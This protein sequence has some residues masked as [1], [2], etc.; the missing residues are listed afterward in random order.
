MLVYV[1]VPEMGSGL[2]SSTSNAVYNPV[3]S[4]F[5]SS[6][7][8]SVNSA[9]SSASSLQVGNNNRC[10]EINPYNSVCLHDDDL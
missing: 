8:H 10:G 2:I 9:T 3:G 6:V 7:P 1:F 5:T 4:L